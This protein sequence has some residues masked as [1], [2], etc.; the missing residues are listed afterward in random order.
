MW[1]AVLDRTGRSF[2]FHYNIIGIDPD[3]R[4]DNGF[5]PRVGLRAAERLESLHAGTESRA[6]VVERF[7]VFGTTQRA[8]ALRRLLLGE[9]P[10]RGSGVADDASDDA[11][12]MERRRVAA[13]VDYAFDPA[14]YSELF[15]SPSDR[16]R[17]RLRRARSASRRR[18]S[19]SSRRRPARRSATTSTSSRRRACGASTTT[20]R[21]ICG[22][23]R[24][25]ASAR[26]TSAAR[27]RAA[28]TASRSAFHEEFRA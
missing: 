3:F 23:A 27:S 7:N 1:E 22:R 25:C 20:R 24:D 16:D 6:R 19:R 2:G 10:A 14:A 28:A 9:E 26:R 11:R 8:L 18:S 17:R 21:S 15:A 12:R 13:A 4:A 5:V